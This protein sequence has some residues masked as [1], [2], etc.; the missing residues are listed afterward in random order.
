VTATTANATD[1]VHVEDDGEIEISGEDT[2]AIGVH[3]P[4]LGFLAG[5]NC[6]HHWTGTVSESGAIDL[7]NVDIAQGPF[8]VGYCAGM[9]DCSGAGWVGQAHENEVGGFAADFHICIVG[10]AGGLDGVPVEAECDLF[11]EEAHCD[12]QLII[13]GTGIPVTSSGLPVEIVGEV[14]VSPHLGLMHA[15]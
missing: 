2:L 9:D 5:L 14:D 13:E 4:T 7:D 3:H 12:D 10:Q 6:A 8:G 11:N 1:A 15:E